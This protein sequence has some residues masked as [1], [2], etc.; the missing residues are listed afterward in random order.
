MADDERSLLPSD[1]LV[2]RQDF[3]V[4]A[5][6][7]AANAEVLKAYAATRRTK[8]HSIQW[9]VPGFYLVWGGGVHTLLRFATTS[10]AGTAWR[11]DSACSTTTIRMW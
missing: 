10:P 11:V 8:I 9:F 2:L 5:G 6:D 4:S 1:R 7:L 3:D